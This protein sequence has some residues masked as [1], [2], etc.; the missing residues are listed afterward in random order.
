MSLGLGLGILSGGLIA[1]AM[2]LSSYLFSWSPLA[3]P[4][5]HGL[6]AG[7]LH[8]SISSP[9]TLLDAP[10]LHDDEDVRLRPVS[11]NSYVYIY[12]S[13]MT[14]DGVTAAIM[15]ENTSELATEGY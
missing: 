9:G 1:A 6:P 5:R 15:I 12:P 11:V 14:N 3:S 8:R 13:A 10:L 2:G 4:A 7:T